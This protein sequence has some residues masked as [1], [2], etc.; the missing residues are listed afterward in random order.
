MMYDGSGLSR[1]NLISPFATVTLLRYMAR[2]KYFDSCFTLLP[3][4][5]VDGTLRNRMRATTAEG[6][7]HAKTGYVGQVRNLSGYVISADDEM[8]MFSIL[9]NHYAIATPAINLLQ[10][11]IC[12]R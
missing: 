7:V 3:I 10:D 11:R 4:S 8:F 6:S 9:V 1:K 5:G 12:E 2:H